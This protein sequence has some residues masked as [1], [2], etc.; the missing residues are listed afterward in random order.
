M[1]FSAARSARCRVGPGG[2][3]ELCFDNVGVSLLTDGTTPLPGR[4]L[5]YLIR[6]ETLCGVGGYG[7]QKDLTPRTST[8]CP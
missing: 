7:T 3:D 6:A 1:T 2:G 8:T 4:G 5:W